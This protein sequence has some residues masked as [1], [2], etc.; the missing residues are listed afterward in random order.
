MI[1]LDHAATTPLRREA[2]DAM[3]PFLT[4]IFGNPSSAHAAGR[5]A[6]AALDEAHET[7]AR[8]LNGAPRE[9]VFTS[10]GTE[11]INLAIKGAAWASKAHGNQII[12]T[13]VEHHAALHAVQHLERFGFEAVVLPVDRYGRVDPDAVAAAI[14]DRT[15]LVTLM[16]ANNEVGTIQPIA[17]IIDRVRQHPRILVHLDAVQA[18][19]YLPI[20]VA[21]LGVDM[22]S[23]GAHKFEGP[24]GTGALWMRH[25]TTIL[26]QT[27][28]GS[29]E[30]YRRAGTEDVAG[31]V[32]L[33]AAFDL[34]TRERTAEVRRLRRLRDRLRDAILAVPGVELTGH[35]RERLPGHL[36]VICRDAD[37]VSITLALDL[38]GICASTGSACTTGSPEPSH[39]L[40]ALGYPE[41]EALGA[42]RMSLGRQTTEAEVER[43]VEVI[44]P[45]MARMRAGADA[46]AADPLGQQVPV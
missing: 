42:V 18:A 4:E 25:G 33:A 32:G 11:A 23:I 9:V 20:D 44:P 13:A 24:K 34:C 10:G 39:V 15:I 38:E 2:L 31:A 7:V 16:L 6:K 19:P 43:A 21:T 35:P 45:T 41:E 17:E 36:S 40:T 5:K 22:V 8:I 26:P 1:Y 27:Q 12:T 29:Q 3:L 46:M 14:T 37:G 30:R 28:G